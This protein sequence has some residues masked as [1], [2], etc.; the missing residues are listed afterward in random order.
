[1]LLGEAST[2]ARAC[3][4]EM[5]ERTY[6]VMADPSAVEEVIKF[7]VESATS[8]TQREHAEQFRTLFATLQNVWPDLR[9]AYRSHLE[10]LI[11]IYGRMLA[12]KDGL[13]NEEARQMTLKK[14]AYLQSL[15]SA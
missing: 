13:P 7:T 10:W 1:M 14:R 9:D 6:A 15:L 3:L 8:N 5:V 12:T 11:D 4:N 2:R